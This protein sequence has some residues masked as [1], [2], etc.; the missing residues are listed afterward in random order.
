MKISSLQPIFKGFQKLTADDQAE[1]L[2]YFALVI[3]R[4]KDAKEIQ[5]LTKF[6]TKLEKING[7]QKNYN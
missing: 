7:S 1:Y 2:R 6:K 4:N 5:V 3:E